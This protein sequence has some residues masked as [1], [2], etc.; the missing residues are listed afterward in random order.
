[1]ILDVGVIPRDPSVRLPFGGSK[2]CL[3]KLL[4][5]LMLAIIKCLNAA[6]VAKRATDYSMS[7]DGEVPCKKQKKTTEILL[8]TQNSLASSGE[9]DASIFTLNGSG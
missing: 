5:S 1:M 2:K 7:S 4:H 9:L 8:L 6:Y 3:D